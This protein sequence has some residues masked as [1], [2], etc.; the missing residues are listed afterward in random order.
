MVCLY[1]LL[2]LAKLVNSWKPLIFFTESSV[3]DFLKKDSEYASA[4]W[5]D[6]CRF[7]YI[8]Q[9]EITCIFCHNSFFIFSRC[10]LCVE[11]MDR[12]SFTK[13]VRIVWLTPAVFLCEWYMDTWKLQNENT[14][15]KVQCMAHENIMKITVS[16]CWW[17]NKLAYRIAQLVFIFSLLYC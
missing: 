12:Q 13:Q 5:K 16:V 11:V 2:T 15:W 9:F 3:L 1:L 7:C 10:S 6:N 14:Q 8:L 4:A 17:P